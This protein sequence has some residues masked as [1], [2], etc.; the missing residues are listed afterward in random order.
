MYDKCKIFILLINKNMIRI[1]FKI[2]IKKNLTNMTI[3]N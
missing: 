3:S 2:I 1:T